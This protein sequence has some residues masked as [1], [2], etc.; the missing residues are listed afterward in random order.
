MVM[1]MHFV[2]PC[3]EYATA[4]STLAEVCPDKASCRFRINEGGGGAAAL[5][6]EVS[7]DA[8]EGGADDIGWGGLQLELGLAD[9]AA[10]EGEDWDGG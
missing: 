7:D 10:D 8:G 6:L 4:S 3:S 1:P 5:G 9:F 2:A